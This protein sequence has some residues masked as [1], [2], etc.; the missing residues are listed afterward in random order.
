[1]AAGDVRAEVERLAAGQQH[2]V[3]RGMKRRRLWC[4][5]RE[6][7]DRLGG[8]IGL[9]RGDV[10]VFD[11]EVCCVARGIDAFGAADPCR[12]GRPG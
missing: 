4:D 3:N 5:S 9:L 11:G 12:V 8:D 7:G 6:R 1:V 10:T 2:P